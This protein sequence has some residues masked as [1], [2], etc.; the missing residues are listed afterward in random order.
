[1]IFYI[2]SFKKKNSRRKKRNC[3]VLLWTLIFVYKTN[4]FSFSALI[5]DFSF[6]LTFLNFR[7]DW[8]NSCFF[9]IREILTEWGL[10]KRT[11]RINFRVLTKVFSM[12]R[13][14]GNSECRLELKCFKNEVSTE[15]TSLYFF[16][17]ICSSF[18][19]QS[20]CLLV[21]PNILFTLR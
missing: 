7:I 2:T 19:Q 6:T 11:E 5:W 16:C 14:E 1:M 15:K 10:A 21:S 20:F 4:F 13:H 8:D 17:L 12:Y 18:F 9:F 3:K